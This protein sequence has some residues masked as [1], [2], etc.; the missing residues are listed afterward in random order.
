MIRWGQVGGLKHAPRRLSHARQRYG[1][2]ILSNFPRPRF[3]TSSSVQQFG[4]NQVEVR[5][6]AACGLL[7]KFWRRRALRTTG[8]CWDRQN[9]GLQQPPRQLAAKSRPQLGF[10]SALAS[11]SLPGAGATG[12]VTKSTAPSA[13]VVA[14]CRKGLRFSSAFM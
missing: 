14:P 2:G 9:R 5:A 10:A 12:S 3:M 4:P 11:A 1:E 7:R 8:L 6:C 13:A